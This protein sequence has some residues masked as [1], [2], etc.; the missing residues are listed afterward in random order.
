M[1]RFLPD[2]S[3]LVAAVCSWHEHHAATVEHEYLRITGRAQL[4][5]QRREHLVE[6]LGAAHGAAA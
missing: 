3:C 1:T 2:T 6:F 5:G 4:V